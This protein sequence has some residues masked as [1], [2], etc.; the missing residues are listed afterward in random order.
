M[1]QL[2][3]HVYQIHGL[4]ALAQYIVLHVPLQDDL[5]GQ[6]YEDDGFAHGH[7]WV[8]YQVENLLTEVRRLGKNPDDWALTSKTLR[9]LGRVRPS[10]ARGPDKDKDRDKEE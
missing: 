2:P 3:G 7:L 10:L 6:V 9:Q 1:Y 8:L 4:R 5:H